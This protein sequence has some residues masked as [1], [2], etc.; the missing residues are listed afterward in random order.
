MN[1]LNA[2]RN[3]TE[4]PRKITKVSF[5][6]DA[7]KAAQTS[8]DTM[9]SNQEFIEA[10]IRAIACAWSHNFPRAGEFCSCASSSASKLRQGLTH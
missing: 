4:N 1:P 3:R 6:S 2:A 9:K 8:E 10:N 7:K 5:G